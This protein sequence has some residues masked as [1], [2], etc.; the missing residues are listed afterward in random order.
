MGF[1]VFSELRLPRK[2]TVKDAAL[3]ESL[4]HNG[5]SLDF[6]KTVPRWRSLFWKQRN[7]LFQY[8]GDERAFSATETI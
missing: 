5:V 2:S 7:D 8:D 4:L 6:H 1:F 3:F